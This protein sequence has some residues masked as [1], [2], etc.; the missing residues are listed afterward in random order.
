MQINRAR[1]APVGTRVLS[2]SSQ[3]LSSRPES[4]SST[5]APPWSFDIPPDPPSPEH[6][7]E[8]LDEFEMMFPQIILV[9][10]AFQTLQYLEQ[11]GQE[12]E[13]ND[14]YLRSIAQFTSKLK[15]EEKKKKR[16]TN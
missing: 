8:A 16:G 11:F 13:K 5:H 7:D 15:L 9:K 4:K 3:M 14:E 1:T 12:N 2:L 10:H 6:N